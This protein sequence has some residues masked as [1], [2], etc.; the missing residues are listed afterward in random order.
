MFPGGARTAFAGS[1]VRSAVAVGG[2]VRA[3]N[4]QDRIDDAL[5]VFFF[6]AVWAVWI[7]H[8]FSSRFPISR[9]SKSLRLLVEWQHDQLGDFRQISSYK[10]VNAVLCRSSCA[11]LG[12][13]RA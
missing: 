7:C 4:S 12:T 3:E 9:L 11:L 6:N 13:R 2:V 8:D 1:F 10:R 5:P